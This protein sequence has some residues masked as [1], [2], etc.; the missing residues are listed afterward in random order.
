MS[1]VLTAC[2]K[3]HAC[4]LSSLH[5][6]YWGHHCMSYTV[7]M[8]G[9]YVFMNINFVGLGLSL[10]IASSPDLWTPINFNYSGR[11]LSTRDKLFLVERLLLSPFPSLILGLVKNTVGTSL[12]VPSSPVPRVQGGACMV[13]VLRRAIRIVWEEPDQSQ[14]LQPCCILTSTGILS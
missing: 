2:P 12:R 11:S 14:L 9:M 1:F 3:A 10:P 6:M 7:P 8:H 5:H 13:H 4:T